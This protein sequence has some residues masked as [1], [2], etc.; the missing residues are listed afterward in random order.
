MKCALVD[1]NFLMVP[2][3][4]RVDVFVGLDN[5]GYKPI[6]LSCVLS[7][8]NKIASGKGKAG[9]QARVALAII[10]VRKPKMVEARSPADRALL[11]RAAESGCAIATNDVALIARAKKRG[12]AILRLRQKKYV[13]ED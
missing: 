1:T 7:E 2:G 13:V 4:F 3:K 6:I 8:L 9:E 10:D 5:L 11:S 12:I